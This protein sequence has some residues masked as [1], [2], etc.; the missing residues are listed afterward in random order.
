MILLVLVGGATRN[1]MGMAV[2]FLGLLNKILSSGFWF[3]GYEQEE[4]DC[5]LKVASVN[6]IGL[7]LHIRFPLSTGDPTV[8]T[9]P[10]FLSLGLT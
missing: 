9:I 7:L 5:G 4:L 3:W 2:C 8:N 1:A 6:F 10:K